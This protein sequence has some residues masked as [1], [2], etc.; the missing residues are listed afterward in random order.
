M[1]HGGS[2]DV[3]NREVFEKISE[4]QKQLTESSYHSLHRL[5]DSITSI[6]ESEDNEEKGEQISTYLSDDDNGAN[7]EGGLRPKTQG[8]WRGRGRTEQR[9]MLSR[10]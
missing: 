8:P 5:D 3:E 1:D 7:R 10:P 9:Q 2:G 6:C 4:L